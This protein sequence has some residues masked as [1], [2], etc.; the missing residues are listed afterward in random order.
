MSTYCSRVCFSIVPTIRLPSVEYYS[1]RWALTAAVSASV[2][3]GLFDTHLSNIML[4]I[5][6]EH[7]QQPCLLQY[8]SVYSTPICW[9]LCLQLSMSTYSSRVCFSIVRSIR[10]PFVEYYSYRWALTAAVSASVLLGL[11]DFHLSNIML[12]I[13]DEH[14][15]QPCL[16]QYCSDYSTSICRILYL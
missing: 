15:Q 1:F 2:L 13:I 16:L 7:L 11:F 4:T 9:I 10:L 3:F 12:T 6:D 5:I 14:I 8:C